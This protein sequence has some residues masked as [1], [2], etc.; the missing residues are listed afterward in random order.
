MEIN[1][2]EPPSANGGNPRGE[3]GDQSCLAELVHTLPRSRQVRRALLLKEATSGGEAN[4][5]AM[6]TTLLMGEECDVMK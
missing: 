4:K 6:Q 2:G 5:S 1:W 3:G